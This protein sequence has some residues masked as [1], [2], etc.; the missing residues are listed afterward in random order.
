MSNNNII[1]IFIFLIEQV[2]EQFSG[3]HHHFGFR[4]HISLKLSA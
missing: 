1:P 4:L 2:I 3:D